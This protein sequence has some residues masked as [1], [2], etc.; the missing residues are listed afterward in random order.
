MTALTRFEPERRVLE[1]MGIVGPTSKEMHFFAISLSLDAYHEFSVEIVARLKELAEEVLSTIG[2]DTL[3][4]IREEE[5]SKGNSGDLFDL[6]E[7]GYQIIVPARCVDAVKKSI[8][9]VLL[10]ARGPI[11]VQVEA[12]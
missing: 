12:D 9:S 2:A 11:V 6:T 7:R 10:R 1:W 3:E 5:L 4:R 8:E